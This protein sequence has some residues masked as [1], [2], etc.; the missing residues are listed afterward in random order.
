MIRT[1]WVA[2]VAIAA[3]LFYG[4]AMILGGLLGVRRASY[5][6]W[7]GRGWSGIILRA[8]GCPVR[9]EG[10]EHIHPDEPQVLVGNHQS[11]FDVLAVAAHLPKT[12]HFVA[13]KELESVVI[14][15]RAWKAAGHISI[16]RA[17]RASAIASLDQAGRQLQREKSAV[18]VFAE[19]TRSPTDRLLPFKK[20]AF[21][22]A[23]HNEVPVVP[24]AVAGSR[25]VFP[26]GSWRVRTGP[27]IV[28]FGPPID[29]AGVAED[30]RDA[31]IDRVREEVRRMRDD[32]RRELGPGTLETETGSG[33]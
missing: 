23:L 17:N 22:L 13:K 29:T 7:G 32:A 3:T 11:W 2:L 14:F 27:I 30:E 33:H 18:V 21:M 20:G 8:S 10:I 19:G 24:F 4:P 15:G 28:R 6:D 12:F 5:Y 1:V 26:K 16:D 31:L 25:R 9:V